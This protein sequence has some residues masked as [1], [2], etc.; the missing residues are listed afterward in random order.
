MDIDWYAL[1][2]FSVNP[3]EII[4]RG[5]V[6][7]WFIFLLFRLV[8]RRDVGAI[9]I[10]DVMLLVLNLPLVGLWVRV[11]SIPRPWLYGGILVFATVGVYGMRQS[12][13]DLYLLFGA[14]LNDAITI[15]TFPATLAIAMTSP[16][17]NSRRLGRP[18]CARFAAA[19]TT[20]PAA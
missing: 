11:L 12:A 15:E 5:T 7:Y 13:F 1:F 16:V 8:L 10:A 18:A 6:I 2:G 9:A 17:T 4:L 19:Q 14:G 20:K 3:A